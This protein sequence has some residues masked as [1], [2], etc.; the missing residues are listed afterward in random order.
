[1]TEHSPRAF[2]TDKMGQKADSR[3]DCEQ[4]DQSLEITGYFGCVNLARGSPVKGPLP[5][6]KI[7][8]RPPNW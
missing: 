1:V 3:P 8:D 4:Q 2:P 7:L 5:D 6:A